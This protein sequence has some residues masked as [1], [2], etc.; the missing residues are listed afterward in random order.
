VSLAGI[1]AR[2]TQTLLTA[3]PASQP[4]GSGNVIGADGQVRESQATQAAP[5]WSEG[6]ASASMPSVNITLAE[7]A[8]ITL[9]Q[10]KQAVSTGDAAVIPTGSLSSFSNDLTTL[11]QAVQRGDHAAAAKAAMEVEDEL[12]SMS[13][14]HRQGVHPAT[15]LKQTDS[16]SS[17][18][19]DQPAPI[20]SSSG[21]S[22]TI[23]GP[24]KTSTAAMA[25]AAYNAIA[26]F[27]RNSSE[28]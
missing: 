21:S 23:G 13:V 4:V 8:V 1:T 19:G 5:D 16:K 3:Q 9:Q 7:S 15:Q 2:L 18:T 17:A 27:D 12:K 10:F 25:Q 24:G 14:R 22:P 6:S 28:R 26:N 20:L 11:L